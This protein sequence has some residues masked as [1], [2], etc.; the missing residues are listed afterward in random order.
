MEVHG[1]EIQSEAL[2]D[3]NSVIQSPTLCSSFPIMWLPFSIR[4]SGQLSLVHHVH[5][6]DV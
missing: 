4:H 6:P 3:F 5:S 1:K 2:H